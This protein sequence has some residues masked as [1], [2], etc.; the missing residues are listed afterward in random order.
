MKGREE[1]QLDRARA[2]WTR[3]G[4]GPLVATAVAPGNRV[5]AWEALQRWLMQRWSVRQIRR[6]I[7]SRRLRRVVDLGC[8]YGDLTERLAALADDVEAVDYSPGFARAAAARLGAHPSA[9]VWCCD[10]RDFDDWRDPDLVSIGG[11]LMYLR[12]ADAEEVL[13]RAAAELAPRGLLL[14]REFVAVH[15]GDEWREGEL[16]GSY[17][18]PASRYRMWARDAGLEL[19]CERHSAAIFA[20]QAVYESLGLRLELWSRLLEAPVALILRAL[21]SSQRACS[22]TVLYRLPS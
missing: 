9:R 14:H 1:E 2:Y 18:R 10:V 20:A 16:Y 22:W 6:V 13:R 11:V 4:E 12:D 3:A 19:L 15:D 17:R 21:T 8:G 7:P 5:V